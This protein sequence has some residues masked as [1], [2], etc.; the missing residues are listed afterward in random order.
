LLTI[1]YGFELAEVRDGEQ[2]IINTAEYL[3]I[4]LSSYHSG[5]PPQKTARHF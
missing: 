5:L 3:L 1:G 2:L 4:D